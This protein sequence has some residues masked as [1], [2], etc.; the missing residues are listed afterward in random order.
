MSVISERGYS[1]EGVVVG[2]LS[3]GEEGVVF[4]SIPFVEGVRSFPNIRGLYNGFCTVTLGMLD[5]TYSI[6][7]L[8]GGW[9]PFMVVVSVEEL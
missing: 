4:F 9:G 7:S 1:E 6:L 3:G 5:F 8:V 2:R